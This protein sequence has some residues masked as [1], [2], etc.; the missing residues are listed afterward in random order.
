[1]T[2]NEDVFG[3][4][5]RTLGMKAPKKDRE[6]LKERIAIIVRQGIGAFTPDEIAERILQVFEEEKE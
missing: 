2:K 5:W 4:H 1:M 6:E 3:S